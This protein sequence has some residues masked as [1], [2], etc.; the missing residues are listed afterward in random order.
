[1]KILK[2]RCLSKYKKYMKNKSWKINPQKA[3]KHKIK[4]EQMELIKTNSHI[5]YFK[6]N[7]IVNYIK[8]KFSEQLRL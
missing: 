7:C 2:H 5:V 3:G 1:M 8:N 4:R 6:S